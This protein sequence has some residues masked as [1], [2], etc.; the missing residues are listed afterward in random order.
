MRAIPLVLFLSVVAI[1]CARDPAV[2]ILMY[3]SISDQ[4][5]GVTVSPALFDEHLAYL[6]SAG[7]T[8]VTMRQILAADEGTAALPDYPIALTFDD[9]FADGFS[10]ALPLLRKRKQVGTFFVVSGFVAASD[11]ARVR[12]PFAHKMCLTLREVRA[13]RA[14]GMEIGS[15]TVRH[16]DLTALSPEEM[17]AEIEQ[18]KFALEQMLGEPVLSFAY[19][20][21]RRRAREVRAVRD[22]GY[23]L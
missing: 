18:S 16:S 12:D 5:D 10:K 3:H 14:E 15:H 7:F 2:P 21:I 8:T 11:S 6:Q 4:S 13:L 19:P 22:A 17:R 20:F 23:R 1:G 9:A